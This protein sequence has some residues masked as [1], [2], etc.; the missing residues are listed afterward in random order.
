MSHAQLARLNAR[1]QQ[2]GLSLAEMQRPAVKRPAAPVADPRGAQTLTSSAAP[3]QS[4][5]QIP[6]R[7]MPSL[8]A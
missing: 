2:Q 6:S 4:L 5:P 8:E 1:L 7:C 3:L